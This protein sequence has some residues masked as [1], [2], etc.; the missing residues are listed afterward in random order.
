MKLRQKSE[1]NLLKII[2]LSALRWYMIKYDR[3]EKRHAKKRNGE[4]QTKQL[5]TTKD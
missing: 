1:R 3:I 5:E 4:W 2:L